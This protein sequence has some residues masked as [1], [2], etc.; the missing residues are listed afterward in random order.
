MPQSFVMAAFNN[1]V[2]TFHILF[3][4]YT[5]QE[6]EHTRPKWKLNPQPQRSSQYLNS[7]VKVQRSAANLFL[8]LNIMGK[9]PVPSF[10]WRLSPDGVS[11]GE[12]F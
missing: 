10:Y 2:E 6:I 4:R 9:A 8:E 5:T 11:T 12:H 1:R 3:C 7:N